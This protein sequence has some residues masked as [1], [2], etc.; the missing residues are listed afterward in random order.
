MHKI[1]ATLKQARGKM[2]PS[3]EIIDAERGRQSDAHLFLLCLAT[4]LAVEAKHRVFFRLF[5]SSLQFFVL[6]P[7]IIPNETR[8]ITA[9]HQ[10]IAVRTASKAKPIREIV[11]LTLIGSTGDDYRKVRNHRPGFF[12]HDKVCELG[13][14]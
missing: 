6:G 2:S 4:L 12:S 1:F 14:P 11:T 7:F 13:L 5:L 8:S 9:R 10:T 3:C